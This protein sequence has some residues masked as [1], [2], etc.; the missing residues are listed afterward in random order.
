MNIWTRTSRLVLCCGAP[1]AVSGQAAACLFAVP[2]EQYWEA[3]AASVRNVWLASLL[4]GGLILCLDV[5][6]GRVSVPLLIAA[7]LHLLLGW[8]LYQTSHWGYHA[9]SCEPALLLPV[10]LVLGLVSALL[11][12][13]VFRAIRSS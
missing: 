2:I 12:Y 5:Y 3:S 11:A 4:V 10:Q 13:R 7:G 6:Q 8:L 9:P 1:L